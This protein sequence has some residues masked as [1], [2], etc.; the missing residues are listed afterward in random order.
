MNNS[1][2]RERGAMIIGLYSP[3]PQSGKT[4]VANMLAQEGFAA[5]SFA[6]PLKRM[7]C[8]FLVSLGYREDEATRLVW[9]DKPFVVPEVGCSVRHILQTL[10]T[11][12]GRE[13][14]GPDLWVRCWEAQASRQDRVIAD[15]VRFPNE[16]QAVKAKGGRM[17]K[18]VRPSATHDGQHISEG[19]LDDW[20]GFDAVIQ[21]DGSLSDLRAK[22]LALL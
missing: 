8:E 6:S 22:V 17:W 1:Y 15:D 21:N 11:E 12:W 7:A 4:A 14:L 5:V 2:D 3:A 13:R 19:S 16:A 9:T 20:D 18:I 10:G